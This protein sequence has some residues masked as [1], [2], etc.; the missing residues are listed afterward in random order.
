MGVLCQEDVESARPWVPRSQKQMGMSITEIEVDNYCREVVAILNKVTPNNLE[1]LLDKMTSLNLNSASNVGKL[2]HHIVCKAEGETLYGE[3]YAEMCCTLN[4]VVDR[5]ISSTPQST[6]IPLGIF[7]SLVTKECLLAFDEVFSC[8]YLSS[9]N[10]RLLHEHRQRMFGALQF[11]GYLYNADFFKDDMLFGL[12]DR[13]TNPPENNE[14]LYEFQ[15]ECLCKLL[16]VVGATVEKQT[17]KDAIENCFSMLERVR[18]SCEFCS[19]VRFGI[20]DVQEV[21]ANG[22]ARRRL[23]ESPMTIDEIRR[24]YA[25]PEVVVRRQKKKKQKN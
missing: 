23:Q 14:I 9:G 15:I 20:L 4:Q 19:R 10:H 21:R 22:W 2:V 7:K 5:C 12:M 16:M 1:I 3:V 13:L 25:N 18:E 24:T 6:D 17:K 11:L 8:E